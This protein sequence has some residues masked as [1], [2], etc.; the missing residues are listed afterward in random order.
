LESLVANALR[1]DAR[2]D[3]AAGMIV[4]TWRGSADFKDPRAYLDGYLSS[5][6]TEAKG[7]RLG[8]ELRFEHMDYASSSTLAAIV[9]F[10]Q[11]ARHGGLKLVFVFD[12]R[13]RWQRLSFEALRVFDVGDGGLELRRV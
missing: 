1:I 13:R 7:S 10:T 8:I 12:A 2:R 5:V 6:L 11:G 4:L 3:D 9:D